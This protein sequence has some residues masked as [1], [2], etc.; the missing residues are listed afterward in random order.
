MI[1]WLYPLYKIARH[2]L[3]YHLRENAEQVFRRIRNTTFSHRLYAFTRPNLVHITFPRLSAAAALVMSIL[4]VH[5]SMLVDQSP[6][7]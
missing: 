2:G 6:L 1:T 3:A 4:E 7:S 5:R